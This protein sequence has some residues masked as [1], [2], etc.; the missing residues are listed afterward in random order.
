MTLPPVAF[1]LRPFVEDYWATGSVSR[2]C[3]SFRLSPS[4][5]MPVG[6]YYVYALCDPVSDEIFYI[7]K[8]KGNRA[9]QHISAVRNGRFA[10]NKDKCERIAELL[11]LGSA[12]EILILW[13]GASESEALRVERE[14]IFIIGIH[15]LTNS[16]SGNE[17]SN[18]K[19][20]RR[21]DWLLSRS[22]KL[23][24][25]YMEPKRGLVDMMNWFLHRERLIY[26]KGLCLE[27]A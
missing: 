27:K 10:D 7:G 24:D 11:A 18:D 15:R 16:S 12:P 26:L 19:A 25:Y 20:A 6:C 14:T 21:V 8:G 22:K 2:S 3:K 13:S 1:R 17:T 4:K 5:T 9:K 23:E